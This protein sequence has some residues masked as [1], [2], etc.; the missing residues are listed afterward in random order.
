MTRLKYLKEEWMNQ[1][2]KGNDTPFLDLFQ[3]FQ[4]S[5]VQKKELILIIDS[6]I[7]PDPV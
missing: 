7:T 3:I 6:E 2:R 5:G 4:P 1:R